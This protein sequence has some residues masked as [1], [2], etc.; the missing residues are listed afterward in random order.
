MASYKFKTCVTCNEGFLSISLTPRRNECIRCSKD[1][2]ENKLFT[3]ENNI[4]PCPVPPEL[5]DLSQTEE[6]LISPI[7]PMMTT[8]RLPH[9]QLGYS[10]HVIS[11]PQAVDDFVKSLPRSPQEI[12][13][14]IVRKHFTDGRHKDFRVRKHKILAALQWLL[15]NNTYFKDVTIDQETLN[16]LPLDGTLV[17]ELPS[18]SPQDNVSDQ[19]VEEDDNIEPTSSFMPLLSS[20]GNTEDDT[21]RQQIAQNNPV[22]WPTVRNTPVNEFQ[23]EGYFSLAFPTLFPDATGDFTIPRLRPVTIGNYFK[24]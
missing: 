4:H 18:F 21:I 1:Q 22:S 23:H 12:C 14:L 15:S 20:S 11:L 10:G 16:E 5:Q 6:M 2:H 8:Y 7:M 3:A 24:H 17:S 9:G 13:V 19:H